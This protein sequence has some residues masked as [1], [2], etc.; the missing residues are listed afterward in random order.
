[1]GFLARSLFPAA[2]VTLMA[3]NEC[4]ETEMKN[5][6]IESGIELIEIPKCRRLNPAVSSHPDMQLAHI[7]ENILV[8]H[9]DFPEELVN[10]L[11]KRGFEVY[12]GDTV[13][14]EQYPFDIAYNVAI[15]GKEAFHNA[16]Y[17]DPVIKKLLKRHSIRLNHVN[18]GYAKCSVLPVTPESVITADRSI[19]KA[20]M[21]AGYDVLLIPAQ[22]TIQLPG[23]DYGFIGG[24]A[25]FIDN[26][27]LVFAGN[28]EHL[29]SRGDIV[30]FL[31]KHNISW[32]NLSEEIIIDYGGFLP[33]YER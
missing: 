23:F 9:P 1:M 3:V 5:R 15:I 19:A 21:D 26:E 28:V 32:I 22:R 10:F 7:N 16:K 33:L 11:K 29:E 12:I 25:G 8:C 30:R 4:I 2:N 18:Q 14:S 13:L 6:L 31:K 24:T 27:K 20:A 17:T